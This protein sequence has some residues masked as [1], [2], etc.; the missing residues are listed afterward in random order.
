MTTPLDPGVLPIILGPE[1][2][3]GNGIHATTQLSLTALEEHVHPGNA[4]LDLGTGTGILAMAAARLGA[5]SVLAVDISDEAVRAA[6]CNVDENDLGSVVRVEQGSL[7][8]ALHPPDG[9]SPQQADVVVG[10]LLAPIILEM[11]EQGLVDA[12]KPQGVLILSGLLVNQRRPVMQALRRVGMGRIERRQMDNWAVLV[13]RRK[14]RQ[15]RFVI[16]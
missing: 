3:F 7:D 12:V 11:I 8:L 14:T 13:A 6:R 9:T 10:N 16:L 2:V 1:L 15:F 5:A 4:V